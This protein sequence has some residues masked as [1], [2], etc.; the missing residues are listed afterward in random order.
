MST[1]IFSMP[2]PALMYY[3]MLPSSAVQGDAAVK[4]ISKLDEFEMFVVR[5]KFA[6]LPLATNKSSHQ[7][8]WTSWVCGVC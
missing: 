3:A 6:A 4:Y 7:G 2:Y 8:E 5:C 1:I